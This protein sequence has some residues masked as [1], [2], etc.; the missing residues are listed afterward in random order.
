MLRMFALSAGLLLAV[1]AG[2]FASGEEEAAAAAAGFNAT[3]YP[4]STSR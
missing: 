4:I 3:G 2:A 1:T